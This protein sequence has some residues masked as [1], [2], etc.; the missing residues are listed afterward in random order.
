MIFLFINLVIATD[1]ELWIPQLGDDE[2]IIGTIADDEFGS[3]LTQIIC[4]NA[5]CDINETNI[6]CPADCGGPSG[7]SGSSIVEGGT[8]GGGGG[9]LKYYCGDRVCN[10]QTET[11]INCPEDCAEYVGDEFISNKQPLSFDLDNEDDT[12]LQVE[13]KFPFFIFII[14]CFVVIALVLGIIYRKQFTKSIKKL[15]GGK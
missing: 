13:S 9:G 1:S 15:I 8:G 7:P 12:L 11:N 6:N 4:G 5:V 3:F 10:N 2:L 14:I